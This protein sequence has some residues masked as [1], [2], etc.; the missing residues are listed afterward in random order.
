MDKPYLTAI[1][2]DDEPAI[3]EGL[4]SLSVWDE[5]G[6]N[7]IDTASSGDKALEKIL[8]LKPDF[9]IMDIMMP[10]MTGLEVL[11]K[12]EKASRTKLISD[13]KIRLS[14]G[15]M[16]TIACVYVEA[17]IRTLTKVMKKN[18]GDASINFLDLFTV[19]SMAGGSQ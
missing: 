19:S 12:I 15:Y 6:I 9:A 4:A 13:Y 18:H 10:G 5:L 16:T 8:T 1:L 7:V 11:E 14:S 2:A 3:T 17:I